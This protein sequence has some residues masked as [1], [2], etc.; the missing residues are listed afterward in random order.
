MG[1]IPIA[2]AKRDGPPNAEKISSKLRIDTHDT[3][4]IGF[5]Y[6][7]CIGCFAILLW[8]NEPHDRLREARK[9]AS[10]V[11]AID[12]ARAFGW[13]PVT[14]RAHE[15]GVEKGGRGLRPDVAARYAKAFRVPA[16]W[17]LFG[18]RPPNGAPPTVR[19]VPLIGYVLDGT[20]HFSRGGLGEVHAPEG[21]NEQTVAVE[22]R[23]DSLGSFFDHWLVF[24]DDVHQPITP[25]LVG[26]ICVLG[27]EDGRVLIKKVMRSRTKGIFHL[28]SQTEDPIL[29]VALEWAAAVKSMAPR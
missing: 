25:D 27:L 15:R 10:Y 16:E 13:D 28:L 26:K 4:R 2:A 21:S 18:K 14:Y 23:D 8:M 1:L 6:T 9:K 17:L 5:A 19:A 11:R 7:H 24:Y 20:I 12:A 29:D 22:I 3:Y